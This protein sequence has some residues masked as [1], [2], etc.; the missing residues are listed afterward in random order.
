MC[1]NVTDRG[2]GRERSWR[3]YH[4]VKG[5]VR[6]VAQTGGAERVARETGT[7]SSNNALCAFLLLLFPSSILRIPLHGLSPSSVCL[8]VCLSSPPSSMARHTQ[9]VGWD[10]DRNLEGEWEEEE[11]EEGT[12]GDSSDQSEGEV[13]GKIYSMLGTASYQ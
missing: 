9:R 4:W 5:Q 3:Q 10:G 7:E 12:K 1:V 2:G 6:E 8:S 11:K 13:R